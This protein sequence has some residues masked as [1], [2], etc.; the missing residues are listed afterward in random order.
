M[1]PNDVH[2]ANLT[3][4]NRD[5]GAAAL[6]NRSKPAR[7]LLVRALH[8]RKQKGELDLQAGKGP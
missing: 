8:R 3:E 7:I 1:A 2:F 5:I 6:Y 4:I